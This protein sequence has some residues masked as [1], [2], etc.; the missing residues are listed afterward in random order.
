[1]EKYNK[2]KLYKDNIVKFIDIQDNKIIK[3]NKL[4]DIDYLVGILFLTEMNRYC[5]ANKI[6]I[7]GYYIAYSLINLFRKIRKK[8]IE[9][10]KITYNDINFIWISIALNID[11]LNSRIDNSNP[12]KNKINY[13]FSKIII[14]INNVLSSFIL[15]NKIHKDENKESHEHPIS[16][17]SPSPSSSNVSNN[18]E[19][20]NVLNLNNRNNPISNPSSNHSS[21]PSSNPSSSSKDNIKNEFKQKLHAFIES[22]K[23]IYDIIIFTKDRHPIGHRS[24]SIYPPHCINSKKE[25]KFPYTQDKN[26]TNNETKDKAHEG[27]KLIKTHEGHSLE[28]DLKYDYKIALAETETADILSSRITDLKSLDISKQITYTKT[29]GKETK[30][31]FDINEITS[32][33]LHKP[34][35]V[36][37]VRLNKGELCN[38]DAYGAFLYHIEYIQSTKISNYNTKRAFNPELS[39]DILN[40]EIKQPQRLTT[41]LAEFINKFYDSQL[42]NVVIDVCGLVTNICVV[43]T[44]IGGVKMFNA[45]NSEQVPKFRLLNEYSLTLYPPYPITVHQALQ[46]SSIPF[47]VTDSDMVSEQPITVI[48]EPAADGYIIVKPELLPPQE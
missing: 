36:V 28:E 19:S 18:S 41:G 31:T 44:C 3:S 4:N 12:I 14:E 27:H 42:N 22:S 23:S 20:I 2:I 11:Y 48:N 40:Q 13:N 39:I 16:L 7:H 26:K 29:T 25:C 9:N 6:T 24:F 37:I 38:F 34:E 15:Y 5:K 8:L 1:M 45:M 47:V 32:Q 35:T 43:N 33:E 21:N 17:N 10:Y 46:N 30:T